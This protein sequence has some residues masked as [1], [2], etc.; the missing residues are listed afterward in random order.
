ML[1][2]PPIRS[3][4]TVYDYCHLSNS[5]SFALILESWIQTVCYCFRDDC[6]LLANH[7][8]SSRSASLLID[9]HLSTRNNS[10]IALSNSPWITNRIRIQD[11]YKSVWFRGL[12]RIFLFCL[13]IGL[14]GKETNL[15]SKNKITNWK[16]EKLDLSNFLY[17]PTTWPTY[18]WYQQLIKLEYSHRPTPN[19]ITLVRMSVST[20]S[21]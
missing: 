12:T 3:S 2:W 15:V 9:A 10:I 13:Q 20:T 7:Y 14:I 1:L 11:S 4:D 16:E 21:S 8:S 17:C 18:N 5:S 6:P 19:P